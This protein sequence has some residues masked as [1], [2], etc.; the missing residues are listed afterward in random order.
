MTTT[1]HQ[2][3]LDGYKAFRAEDYKE[4]KALYEDLGRRG[5]S[6]KV[7]LIGCADSRVDPTDIFNASPGEMFVARNVANI[8]PPANESGSCDEVASAIQYAVT[9]LKVEMIVVM[10]HESCGGIRGCFDG[11]G[12]DP[13]AGFVGRWVSI[14]NGARDRVLAKNLPEADAVHE[15]E[16][17]GVRQSLENLKSYAFVKEAMDAGNLALQGAYFSIF[18]AQLLFANERGEFNTVDP[19]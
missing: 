10:G 15:L 13:K 4:Q 7:M 9:V 14:M 6:P 18:R 12:D 17:E 3:L 11:M 5:Q 19:T 2:R 8:V 16:L 1:S